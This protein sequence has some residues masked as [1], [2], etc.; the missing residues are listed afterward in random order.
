MRPVNLLDRAGW[1]GA[2]IG[3]RVGIHPTEI[4]GVRI[5][6]VQGRPDWWALIHRSAREPG[7]WQISSFDAE[8]PWGHTCLDSMDE[9]LEYARPDGWRLDRAILNDGS[10]VPIPPL[11]TK[12][13]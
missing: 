5:A 3:A 2:M 13:D 7:R 10:D 12:E 4:G 1:T 6:G 11:T 8:G 9:C